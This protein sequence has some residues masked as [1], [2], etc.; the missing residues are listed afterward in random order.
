MQAEDFGPPPPAWLVRN[1]KRWRPLI[2]RWQPDMPWLR[3]EQGVALVMAVIAQESQGFPD[4]IAGDGAASVGLMQ[5]TP[6]SWTGTTEKLLQPAWNLYM[7]MRILNG[8]IDVAG[9]D[10]R[11]GVAAFNCGFESLEAGRCYS[12]GGYAYADRVLGYWRPVF[13]RALEEDK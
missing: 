7:G 3:G 6:R 11:K 4:A 9:G 1:V 10:V 5:V 2:K 13:T 8:A 12:F